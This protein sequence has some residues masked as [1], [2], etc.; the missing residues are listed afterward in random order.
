MTISQ[1][2]LPEGGIPTGNTAGRPANPVIG[3]VY[4][5]GEKGILEIFD[6][7]EFIACSAPAAS[8]TIS[9][10][11]VGTSVA[12]GSA[13]GSV[14][15]TPGTVGGTANSY[16]IS[17]STGGY[18]ATTSG[19]TVT[20]TVGNNGSWTFSGTGANSF[21][22]SA[23]GPAVTQTLTTVPQAPTIGTATTSGVTSD[24]TVTWT[25][26]STGGKNL[27]SI[28]ITPYLNGTTAQTATTAATTSSTSATIVGLTQGSSYTFKVKATNANGTGL[29]SS[30][31]NSITVPSFVVVDYLVVA[32]GGA[33]GCH[34]AAGG[35]AGGLRS[36]VTASGGSPGTV[37]TALALLKSTNYTVTVG[38]G[39]SGGVDVRG[40]DGSNSV[41]ST[42]TSTGGGGGGFQGTQAGRSGGS[43]GG[44][45]S[46]SGGGGAATANQGFPGGT[47]SGS[48]QNGGSG[49]GGAAAAGT[50]MTSSAGRPGGA[51]RQINIDGSNLYYAG[52]G[53]GSGYDNSGGDGGIGGGGGGGNA[54]AGGG[55][56]GTGGGSAINSGGN[57]TRANSDQGGAGG[58]NTG[59]GG[60]ATNRPNNSG[61][62]GGSGIVTLRWLTSGNT[63]TV[64][65]G[66][67]ADATGTDGSY[68]YKRFTAGSGNVSFS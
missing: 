22:E 44:G 20:I 3:D 4:Y 48:A 61:G 51:G 62:A 32:G 8:P 27:S 15:I 59:G 11:D 43:G 14:T 7:S 47:A 55:V 37:E 25:L 26:N 30:A 46:G 35:G 31:S 33:G 63:I 65:A 68:S 60:G 58:A 40:N 53:G 36:T 17:S 42:I 23:P 67:T 54:N 19:T 38:G 64:G 21:G 49:G 1:F 24:V 52:G 56:A 28:T 9:V 13:Q 34:N 45:A 57:G 10:A 5:N 29:E 16:I 6:G 66:L 50:N 18:S 2:P 39:G 41:F 12:Y